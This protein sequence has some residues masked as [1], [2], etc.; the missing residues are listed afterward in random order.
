MRA[1]NKTALFT[2]F[3]PF[4]FKTSHLKPL[5]YG[6]TSIRERLKSIQRLVNTNDLHVKLHHW[7]RCSVRSRIIYRDPVCE[8]GEMYLKDRRL[9]RS[10]ILLLRL[11]R[12]LGS[13]LQQLGSASNDK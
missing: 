4:V 1:L 13:L 7:R 5:R 10:T 2:E 9:A 8:D 12:A 11:Y 6:N 3:F